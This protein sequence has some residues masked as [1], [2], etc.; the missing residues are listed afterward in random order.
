MEDIDVQPSGCTGRSHIGTLVPNVP[1]SGM[2]LH[3][4]PRASTFGPVGA[5]GMRS[6]APSGGTGGVDFR[7]AEK[8]G[9]GTP[10][11]SE[12]NL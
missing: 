10:I 12:G 6:T 4:E 7:G 9:I 8:I 5:A 3:D 1:G 2:A 11:S